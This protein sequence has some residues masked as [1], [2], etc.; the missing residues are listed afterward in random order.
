METAVFT[1][2][3]QILSTL[4]WLLSCTLQQDQAGSDHQQVSAIYT[5]QNHVAVNDIADNKLH[6]DMTHN[7]KLLL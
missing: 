3:G 6:T 7:V 2:K 1:F 4:T 5:K